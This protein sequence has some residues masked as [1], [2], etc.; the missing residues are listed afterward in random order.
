MTEQIQQFLPD[1]SLERIRGGTH[2]LLAVKVPA[3]ADEVR[4]FLEHRS[5][6]D[7]QVVHL[8]LDGIA[9]YSTFGP[10]LGHHGTQPDPGSGKHRHSFFRHRKTNSA[11]MQ[12]KVRCF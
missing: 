11:A 5:K 3:Q 8:P 10:T 12:S 4:F 1:R 7:A 2:E 6:L 9:R